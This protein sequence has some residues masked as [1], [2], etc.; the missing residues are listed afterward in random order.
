MDEYRRNRTTPRLPE[1]KVETETSRPQEAYLLQEGDRDL[2]LHKSVDKAGMVPQHARQA[3]EGETL[4]TAEELLG[5]REGSTP[6]DPAVDQEEQVAHQ[7][8]PPNDQPEQ[9]EQRAGP[10]ESR[11]IPGGCSSQETSHKEKSKGLGRTAGEG[12]NTTSPDTDKMS[13]RPRCGNTG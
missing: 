7:P 12:W 9:P 10:G 1:D 11:T 6:R 2:P 13:D 3:C 8:P 4:Q 5:Q